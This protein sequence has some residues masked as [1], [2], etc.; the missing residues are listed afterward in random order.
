MA[1]KI[2]NGQQKG[3]VG[4]TTDSCMEAIVAALIFNKKVCL[5][6]IDL[7]ANAT[8]FLAKSFNVTEIEKL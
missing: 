5:I 2:I 1:Y 6:D 8:S 4:K 3:G 7:Q